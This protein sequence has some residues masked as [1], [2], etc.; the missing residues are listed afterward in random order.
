LRFEGNKVLCTS[1]A[2]LLLMH[3]PWRG[4][5]SVSVSRRMS[6]FLGRCFHK[7]IRGNTELLIFVAAQ[8]ASGLRPGMDQ[9]ASRC[10]QR[11]EYS[12]VGSSRQRPEPNSACR[13]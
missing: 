12:T 13:I 5:R 10:W 11:W 3:P 8:T 7:A 6:V 1:C 9:A 2:L 4:N